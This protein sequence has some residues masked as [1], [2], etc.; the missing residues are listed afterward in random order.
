MFSDA[1]TIQIIWICTKVSL[2]KSISLVFLYVLPRRIDSVLGK[3]YAEKT[4]SSLANVFTIPGQTREARR[5]DWWLSEEWAE[6]TIFWEGVGLIKFVL[7]A[8]RGPRYDGTS[9][10]RVSPIWTSY[11]H[12]LWDRG[13]T[14]LFLLFRQVWPKRKGLWSP[15]EVQSRPVPS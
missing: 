15:D 3:L 1:P 9:I 6:S 5:I 4:S 11:M 12:L 14:L 13:Y 10:W 7:L 2:T 8:G